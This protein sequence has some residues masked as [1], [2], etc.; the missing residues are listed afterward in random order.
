MTFVTEPINLITGDLE[1]LLHKTKLDCKKRKHK[2]HN[3][4]EVL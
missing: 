4:E 3:M 2:L 1:L